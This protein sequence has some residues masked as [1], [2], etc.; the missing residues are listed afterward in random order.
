VVIANSGG[1]CN[2]SKNP[3]RS[4]RRAPTMPHRGLS[5][6]LAQSLFFV[7]AMRLALLGRVAGGVGLA[8]AGSID[9]TALTLPKYRSA[10]WGSLKK[11]RTRR[12]FIERVGGGAA[13][14]QWTASSNGR[15]SKGR[16]PSSLTP[17]P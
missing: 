14:F 2:G 12:G 13:L 3:D 16:K 11:P 10:H 9:Y 17:S 1:C 7:S 6:S 15:P 8:T 4:L 5:G